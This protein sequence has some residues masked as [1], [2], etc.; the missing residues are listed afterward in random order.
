MIYLVIDMVRDAAGAVGRWLVADSSGGASVMSRPDVTA[1][2]PPY[3]ELALR[4]GSV[5]VEALERLRRIDEEEQQAMLRASTS[6]L[7]HAADSELDEMR[8][9]FGL[10]PS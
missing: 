2:P 9:S 7:R 4:L 1:T 6:L 5:E 8:Q 3:S 10:V